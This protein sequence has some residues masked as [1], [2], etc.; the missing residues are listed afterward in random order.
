MQHLGQQPHIIKM[1]AGGRFIEQEQRWPGDR[2]FA[3]RLSKA[4]HQFEPLTLTA[5]ERIHRL[6]KS[7]V[8]QPDVTKQ[9]Q[10]GQGLGRRP[11]LWEIIEKLNHLIRRRLKQIGDTPAPA[12]QPR[13]EYVFAVTPAVALGTLDEHV[14]QELHFDFLKT[15]SP[16]VTTLALRGVKA[17]RPGRQI[18]CLGLRAVGV[19]LS[20]VVKRPDVHRGI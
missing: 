20:D 16:A 7:H 18:A 13:L 3:L 1:Q 9:L 15:G 19:Q 2:A 4:P 5:G 17:E 12:G 14:A 10:L 11:G 6:T 8:A